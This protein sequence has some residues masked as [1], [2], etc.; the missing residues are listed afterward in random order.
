MYQTMPLIILTRGI[1]SRNLSSAYAQEFFAAWSKM[2][3]DIAARSTRG[4]VRIV[5]GSGS[6]IQIE[7]P[8]AVIRSIN[9]VLDL[10]TQ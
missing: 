2:H 9:E 4:V 10:V 8:Q 1:A 6:N 3:D 7:R 5:E